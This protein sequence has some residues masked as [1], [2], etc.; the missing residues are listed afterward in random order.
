MTEAILH[1]RFTEPGFHCWPDAPDRRGYLRDRHRH[2]FHVQVSMAVAH[3]DREVE[4]HD[5]RDEAVRL[6][7]ALGR[8][9]DMGAMSCEAMARKIGAALAWSYARAVEVSVWEDG[10]FGATVRTA[11]PEG[12]AG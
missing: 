11:A 10:E 7:K 12:A 5:V 4:F 1:V 3:D 6:F 2:L 9:G 8:D